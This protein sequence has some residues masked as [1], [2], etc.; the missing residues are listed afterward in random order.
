MLENNAWPNPGRQL[1]RIGH[2]PELLETMTWRDLLAHLL[3][4]SELEPSEIGACD[5]VEMP[6]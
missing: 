2:V 6:G 4:K 3:H 5:G 1:N